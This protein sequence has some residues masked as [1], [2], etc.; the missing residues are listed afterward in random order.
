MAARPH[1]QAHLHVPLRIPLSLPAAPSSP[2][3][4]FINF[5][6]TSAMNPLSLLTLIA[7]AGNRAADPHTVPVVE[8]HG[9]TEE[10]YYAVAQWIM[11]GVDWL[12][13]LVGLEHNQFLSTALYAVAVFIIAIGI[14]Q[15]V[16]W[17][18]LYAVDHL[19]KVVKYDLY[20]RLRD[21]EFF[22]K[23]CRIV[24]PIVFLIFIQFTLTTKATLAS[25]LTRLTWIYI[26]Y[27][28]A[29]ALNTLATVVWTHVDA[30]E[31]KRKLPL[32][33]LVQLIKGIIWILF[34][35]VAV[36]ILAD[37][38]PGSLLA[39]LGAFAAVL[40]LV[41]KDSILGVVAGVQLS[42]N[43]SLHVG[44]WIKVPGTDANGNVIEVSLTAVKV[45]NFD[46][47]VTTIPPY[48]LVSGSFTNYRPMQLS[49]T[50]R[51]CRSYMIDCDSILPTDDKMLAAYARIPLLKDWIEKKIEQ[52][53]AG[54]VQNVNNPEGLVD[55]S[56]ETNLGV[57]RAYLK[58][59]LDAHPHVSHAEADSCFV[60]ALAQ[61][62]SGIPIQI[63]CFTNT[64][65]WLPYE[66]IQSAI[67]EHFAIMMGRF[68]LYT[69]ENASGRDTIVNGVLEAGRDP[70]LYFGIPYPFLREGG[71]PDAPAEIPAEM[72]K[73]ASAPT[74][75]PTTPASSETPSAPDGSTPDSG[76]PAK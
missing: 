55:G 10:S 19:S 30:R 39:G 61:T 65:S 51:I 38:S 2:R 67:F 7:P 62:A 63:Y 21:S 4:L 73:T 71:T 36:A 60:S 9:A 66:A 3:A 49:N 46:K 57:Y 1:T 37:K 74:P 43:D 17:L 18:I 64:S 48:S 53:D 31:N 32:R 23:A 70:N 56:I 26:C 29:M 8:L 14:G 72:T 75:D 16:K 35:I 54:K 28:V 44:D 15:V 12:L 59:Y 42:E 27:V 58:L 33:G 76:S 11:K 45:Q 24:P 6:H 40:M 5:T 47:T 13:H 50:R 41:F 52:R 22:C 25:W 34:A 68:N 20:L 69:F